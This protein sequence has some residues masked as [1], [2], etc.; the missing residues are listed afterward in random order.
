[1]NIYSEI[2]EPSLTELSEFLPES[3]LQTLKSNH[4]SPL[5]GQAAALD[6]MG[7][8]NLLV[9]IEERVEDEY[10]VSITLANEKAMSRKNS[11]FK[12]ILTLCEYVKEVI[13]EVKNAQ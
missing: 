3:D 11:P 4:E 13:E 8:V 2:I 9:C 5:F 1:M 12:S 6:S 10:D 7:L